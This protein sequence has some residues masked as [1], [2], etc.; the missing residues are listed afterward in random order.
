MSDV[1]LDDL[2]SLNHEISAIVKAGIPLELGLRGLS[3][4]VGSRLGRLSARLANRLADGQTLPNALAEEGPAVSPI[5]TAVIEAGLA[6]GKLPEALQ[7]LSESG[8]IIQETR[9]QVF[10]ASLYPFICAGVAYAMFCLFVTMIAPHIVSAAEMFPKRWPIHLI[11]IL[12]QNRDYFTLVIPSV[13]IAALTVIVSLR[14]TVARHPW[15]WLMSFQW[16]TGRSLNWA[17]FTEILALQVEQGAPLPQ[18]F[19]LAADSTT[20]RRLQREALLIREKLTS[21]VNLTNALQSVKSLPPLV[22]W[23]LATGDKQGQL[24]L[25]LR[26][27]T[28]MYR[29]SAI[30]RAT[31]VRVWLPVTMTILFTTVIGLT[32]A[33]AF[34]IPLRAF[35]LGLMHE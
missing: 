7:S 14:N 1:T 21:G 13:F 25:T 23:M 6:S 24:A 20:D 3:G 5:Y 9:R 34:F 4:S 28:E 32:Y 29:R 30:R 33:L 26:Q 17:Q 35:L 27:L 19:V 12:I 31:I 22:R 11:Q 18:A 2:I 15:Q 8:Q 16:I 10:L